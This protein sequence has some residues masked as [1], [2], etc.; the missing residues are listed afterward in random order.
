LNA[1]P[2]TRPGLLRRLWNP[3]GVGAGPVLAYVRLRLVTS[4]LLTVLTPLALTAF[5]V[6]VFLQ[7]RKP[8]ALSFSLLAGVMAC[9]AVNEAARIRLAWRLGQWT[10]SKAE[11][12]RRQGQARRYWARTA[13]H[14]VLLAG[15]ATGAVTLAWMTFGMTKP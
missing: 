4:L 6:A 2:E 13:L 12:I 7:N 14:A 1:L 9:L 5:L 3:P 8:L 10:D 11:P 15:Y